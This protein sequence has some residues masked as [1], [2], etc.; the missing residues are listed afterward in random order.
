MLLTACDWNGSASFSLSE[1]W[2]EQGCD[3]A[4]IFELR[5]KYKAK[6]DEPLF[7]RCKAAF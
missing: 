4:K 5:K 2:E 7:P 6:V 1:S 3:K